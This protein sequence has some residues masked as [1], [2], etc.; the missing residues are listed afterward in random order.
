MCTFLNEKKEDLASFMKHTT[1]TQQRIYNLSQSGHKAVEM[2]NLLA[3]LVRGVDITEEDL[4]VNGNNHSI[5]KFC[6]GRGRAERL[7]F[8]C[9]ATWQWSFSHANLSVRK[10]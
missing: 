10:L 5:L 1:N 3:K 6:V 4:A 7:S 2:S 9:C 8:A